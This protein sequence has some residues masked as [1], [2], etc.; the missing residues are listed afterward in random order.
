MKWKNYE[1]CFKNLEASINALKIES[2]Y[3]IP[4]VLDTLNGKTKVMEGCPS[5]ESQAELIFRSLKKKFRGVYS[6]ME[7]CDRIIFDKDMLK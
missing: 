7:E 5:K 4:D 6:M 2:E 1:E 3:I